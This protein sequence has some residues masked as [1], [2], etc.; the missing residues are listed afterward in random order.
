MRVTEGTNFEMVRESMRRSKEKMENLQSQASTM[1][2]LN[3]PSDDP[4]AAAKIMEIRTDKSN[5]EQYQVNSKMAQTFLSNTDGALADLSEVLIRCK[6]IAIGQSSVGSTSEDTRTSVAEEVAQLLRHAVSIANRRIGDRYLFGGYK[7]QKSPVDPEGRYLGD[8]GQMMIEIG[9]DVFIS[10]N[11]PGLDVFNTEPKQLQCSDEGYKEAY[12][13]AGPENVNYFDEIQKL[14]IGLLSG[15]LEGIRDTLER[16][17]QLN[18]KL[19]ATRSKLGSRLQ[20][21]QYTSQAI[22][23]HNINNAMLGSS[24]EDSDMAQV[25]S[26]LSKEE[27]VF[28]SSLATSKRLIQP[29]LLEFL[30]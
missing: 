5:Q 16:F 2:K 23:R 24:L 30:R 11:V 3:R 4:V 17:D 19:V 25:V 20:G 21:L 26:D 12:P 8:N 6:E 27:N 1:K 15:D 28:K 29:T 13:E 18:A 10:M 22:E 14:R 9:D 7:T